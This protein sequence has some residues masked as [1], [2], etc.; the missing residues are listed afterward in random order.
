MKTAYKIRAIELRKKG[1][2]L[3]EITR[4]IPVSK[5]SLSTWLRGIILSKDAQTIIKS[6]MTNGQI[7]SQ[8]SKLAQTA[9]REKEAY[10]L[11][12]IL[13]DNL[14]TDFSYRKILC[15]MIYHCEGTKN[16]RNGIV[17][18]NSDPRLIRCFLTLFRES[19]DLDEK[20]FRVCVHLHSYHN[21]DQQ[22]N[23]WSKTSSIPVQQFIRPYQKPHSGLY[24]KE[25]Y[26]GCISVRYGDVKI[27]REMK[28]I[29]IQFMQMGL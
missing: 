4:E 1:H 28:A 25:G 20:K 7:A 17:F 8:K 18:T 22:L 15:A 29:A 11:A 23:F 14:K 3:N 5:S 16:E 13:V 2:S 9:F 10:D 12:S 6:K 19:F 24:K 21:K 26:Q 27:A